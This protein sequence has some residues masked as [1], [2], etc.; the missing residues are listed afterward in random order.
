MVVCIALPDGNRATGGED[1]LAI[2][3][4]RTGE[5]ILRP[6]RNDR[7]DSV[8]FHPDGRRL[9]VGAGDGFSRLGYGYAKNPSGSKVTPTLIDSSPSVPTVRNSLA[10]LDQHRRIWKVHTGQPIGVHESRSQ[11]RVG[12]DENSHCLA[13]GS[14]GEE[15]HIWDAEANKQRAVLK[16]RF[17][18]FGI[19]AAAFSPDGTL[20]ATG[21]RDGTARVWDTL[22]G[23]EKQ[24]IKGHVDTIRASRSIPATNIS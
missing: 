13:L 24:Y 18:G 20:V 16:G 7:V 4:I 17:H 15:A 5:E 22:T 10:E 11:L 3:W 6:D 19:I 1:R 12:F 14:W 2:V 21:G 9:A 8:C 23:Q